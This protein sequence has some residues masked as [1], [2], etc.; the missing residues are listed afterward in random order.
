MCSVSVE[1]GI[2][3]GS[4]SV[5]STISKNVFLL[6]RKGNIKDVFRKCQNYYVEECVPLA[7]CRKGSVE[8]CV[9]LA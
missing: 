1:R 4:F 2:S 9:P 3:K 8:E 7:E 6:C 5:R